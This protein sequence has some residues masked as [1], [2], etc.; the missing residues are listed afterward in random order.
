MVCGFNKKQFK[1]ANKNEQITG[2][3]K[4]CQIKIYTT[5]E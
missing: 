2:C 1:K 3:F 5:L 4:I